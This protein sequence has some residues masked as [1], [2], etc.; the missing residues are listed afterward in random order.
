MNLTARPAVTEDAPLLAALAAEAVDEQRDA[1]GGP[2]WSVRETRPAPYV[3]SLATSLADED[4]L[5]IIGELDG[6]PLGY[7]AAHT[8]EL[9][10]GSRLGVISDLFV[11]A[12]ARGVGL[13]E[14]I[15]T[16]LVQWCRDR[17]CRGID[18][19]ALPGNRST[20]N[21]FETFGFTARALVV[22]HV[23]DHEA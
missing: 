7:G 15:M 1:R 2:I 17:G 11:L 20:K 12:D 5:V 4:E 23:L 14:E 19:L 18:A 9:R 13:G 8:E 3:E 22:H 10:D 21:F 6:T 16:P